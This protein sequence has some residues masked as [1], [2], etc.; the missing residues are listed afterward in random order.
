MSNTITCHDRACLTFPVECIR[1]GV[2]PETI[3]TVEATRRWDLLIF[4]HDVTHE[5]TVPMCRRCWAIRKFAGFVLGLVILAGGLGFGMYLLANAPQQA[6]LPWV[7]GFMIWFAAIV[8]YI[9]N[10]HSRWMDR[11]FAGV[12]AGP[13]RKDGTF[14]LWLRRRPL[15]DQIGYQDEPRKYIA[16]AGYA[17]H[18]E[19][20]LKRLASWWGK[21]FLGG[22]FM[23]AGWFVWWD[24]SLLEAGRR[25]KVFLPSGFTLLYD[26]FGKWPPSLIFGI[27][28]ILLVGWGVWQFLNEKRFGV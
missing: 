23:L 10:R 21:C 8:W 7:A 16:A 9:R 15:V 26:L 13:L 25:P 6:R 1:C 14:S 19:R 28:G 3:L 4:E 20:D 24:L 22:F 17:T 2:V 12:S 18:E 5:I 27:P 11:L